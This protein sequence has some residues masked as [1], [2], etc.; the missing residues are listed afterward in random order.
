VEGAIKNTDA[1]V[2]GPSSSYREVIS[3]NT[4]ETYS[5]VVRRN[6]RWFTAESDTAN[7]YIE[8]GTDRILINLNRI[9][10]DANFR[11]ET[12]IEENDVLIIPFRQY[13]VTVAGAVA[14]PGRYPYIPDREWDYY[15]SLAGGFI[16]TRNSFNRVKIQDF[17]GKTLKKTDLIS[18]ETTITAVTNHWLY[19]FNQLAPVVTT[20]ITTIMLGISLSRQ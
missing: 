6:S 11:S 18:P 20:I 1:D 19:Y 8:R 14:L 16:P 7:A 3:F 9:L 10:Y 13:F 12:L 4:G 15:I 5:S 17:N 2:V